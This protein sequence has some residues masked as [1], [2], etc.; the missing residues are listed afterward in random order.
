MSMLNVKESLRKVVSSASANFSESVDLAVMLNKGIKGS[1][2][3]FVDLPH[4]TGKNVT[5]GVFAEKDDCQSALDAGANVVGKDDLIQKILNDN[6]LCDWFIAPPS[7]MQ[8]VAKVSK[9]LGPKG[10][11]PN[12]KLGTVTNKFIDII[13]K[14]RQGRIRYK[15]DAHNIIHVKIGNVACKLDTLQD[16]LHEVL[17]SISSTVSANNAKAKV[18]IFN[19]VY[20]NT[21]MSKG[22]VLL[23]MS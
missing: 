16:N 4:S 8:L 22:S 20:I 13:K 23:K 14:I 12:P 21:T 1:I 2:K 17:N 19:K 10:I 3:S 6:L 7:L 18:S 9:I 5:I 15:S 11:M